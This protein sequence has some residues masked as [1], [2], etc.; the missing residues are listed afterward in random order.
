MLESGAPHPKLAVSQEPFIAE[1]W[2][3]RAADSMHLARPGVDVAATAGDVVILNNTSIHC[4]TVREG[5]SQRIDLR[6]DYVREN[7]ACLLGH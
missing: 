2:R 1:M 5:P 4:G 7:L 6:I 3:N